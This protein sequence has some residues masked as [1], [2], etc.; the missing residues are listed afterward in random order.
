MMRRPPVL[1]HRRKINPITF[2]ST[3]RSQRRRA[4]ASARCC[5]AGEGESR[6]ETA[7]ARLSRT[8]RPVLPIG[9]F[10]PAAPKK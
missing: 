3:G 1:A 2:D 8:R 6:D 10:S 7:V 4:V 5:R 9:T